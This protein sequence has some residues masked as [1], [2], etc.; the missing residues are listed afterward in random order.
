[1]TSLLETPP[2]VSSTR[3]IFPA[4]HLPA[5]PPIRTTENLANRIG[6]PVS[7]Y[8]IRFPVSSRMYFRSRRE[9]SRVDLRSFGMATMEDRLQSGSTAPLMFRETLTV[10]SASRPFAFHRFHARSIAAP[11]TF[12]N[13]PL[14]SNP[15]RDPL[16]DTVARKRT[17]AQRHLVSTTNPRCL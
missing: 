11:S 2:R 13:F 10:H 7:R 8:N 4:L 16:F 6:E 9:S 14:G 12:P 3:C 15:S 5:Y 1:M 17:Q